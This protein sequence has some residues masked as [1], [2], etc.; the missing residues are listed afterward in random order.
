[1]C[2]F[3]LKIVWIT[4]VIIYHSDIIGVS[5][6]G[7]DKVG[8]DRQTDPHPSRTAQGDTEIPRGQ[9]YCKVHGS[10]IGIGAKRP[11]SEI[12]GEFYEN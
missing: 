4:L 1:M 6:K 9:S 5:S 10:I 2:G 7:S 8:Y 11:E 12:V 3:L